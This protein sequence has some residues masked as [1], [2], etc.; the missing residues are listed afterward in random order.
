MDKCSMLEENVSFLNQLG[1]KS[2]LVCVNYPDV[3]VISPQDPVLRIGSS[4][5]ATCT[6][7]SDLSLH[8]STLYW[9]L[10][11]A[12]LSRSTYSVV[13]S[14]VLSVT[15]HSLNGS[16]QQSG[17][18]LVCHGADGSILA[19]SCLYVGSMWSLIIFILFSGVNVFII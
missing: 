5:T 13:S 12:R 18:N 4:L 19:G 1:L 8:A 6:L 16:W 7:S 15:L 14:S 3:A 2:C 11:G 10:N 9:T 17:D